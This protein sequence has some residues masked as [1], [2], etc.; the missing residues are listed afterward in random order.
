MKK[1]NLENNQD[2]FYRVFEQT[3]SGIAFLDF[4]GNFLFVN[5]AFSS[6][7]GYKKEQL[8]GKNISFLYKQDQKKFVVAFLQQIIIM[9]SFNNE[10]L[11]IKKDSSSIPVL[12]SGSLIKNLD[13]K[14]IGIALIIH[15]ISDF[16]KSKSLILKQIEEKNIWIQKEWYNLSKKIIHDVK[17]PISMIAT[18]IDA[19]LLPKVRSSDEKE[20]LYDIKDELLKIEKRIN[21][22]L[23]NLK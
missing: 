1:N 5:N 6:L 23:I 11:H 8:E 3:L 21:S 20:A 4:S 14:N 17:S 7:H 15:N 13:N 2:F 10:N 9:G 12:I 22:L 16:L 19:V 18:A